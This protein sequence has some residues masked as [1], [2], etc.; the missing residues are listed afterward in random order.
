MEVEEWMVEELAVT[1]GTAVMVKRV[2]AMAAVV[3]AV[4]VKVEKEVEE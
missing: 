4:V 2:E 1:V 3:T